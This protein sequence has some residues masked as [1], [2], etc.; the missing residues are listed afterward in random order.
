MGTNA[1]LQ[2]TSSSLGSAEL[3]VLCLPSV[4]AYDE[5]R[6]MSADLTKTHLE[7]LRIYIVGAGCTGVDHPSTTLNVMQAHLSTQGWWRLCP[8]M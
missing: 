2:I 6:Y 7:Q 5:E 1:C 4:P 8:S 3:A